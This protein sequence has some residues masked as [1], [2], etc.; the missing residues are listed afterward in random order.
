MRKGSGLA[1]CGGARDHWIACLP[2]HGDPLRLPHERQFL[3]PATGYA[4]VDGTDV[5]ILGGA[6]LVGGLPKSLSE[7]SAVRPAR[8]VI[9][10]LWWLRIVAA[11]VNV[12][13]APMARAERDHAG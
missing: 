1:G 2:C 10:A 8:L 5:V 9:P 6:A 13:P 7:L 12:A 11:Q 4:V 3:V